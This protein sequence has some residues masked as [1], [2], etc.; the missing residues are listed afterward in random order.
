M[1]LL[2]ALGALGAL[3][4]GRVPPWAVV[5]GCAGLGALVL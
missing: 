2:L 4:L 5:A 1:H 3:A